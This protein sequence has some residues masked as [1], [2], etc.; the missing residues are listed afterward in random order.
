VRGQLELDAGDL[1]AARGWYERS[2]VVALRTGDR[3]V[4]ARSLELLAAIMMAEGRAERAA[5][6]LGNAAALR[7]M[8]DEADP[9]VLR[10]RAAAR[11]ALGDEGF[12]L[13]E[14]RGAAR[15]REELEAAL[16]AEVTSAAGT[17]G[18]PAARTPPR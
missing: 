8:P 1:E 5:T 15:P 12:A 6:L 7:G 3:P 11:A 18:G 9:D 2:L 17:P 14:E 10:V 4:M 16:A 13:A